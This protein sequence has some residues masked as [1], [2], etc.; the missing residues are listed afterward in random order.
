MLNYLDLSNAKFT[1]M[2]PTDLGNM[3]NLHHLDISSSDSSVWVRDL[4]WLLL[5]LLFNI[6]AWIMSMLPTR[7]TSCFEL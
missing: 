3:S 1:G 4:S 6:L 7:P 2:V 5:C